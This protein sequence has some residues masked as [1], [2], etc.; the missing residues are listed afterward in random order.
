VRIGRAFALLIGAGLVL[1][2]LAVLVLSLPA[3]AVVGFDDTLDS[4]TQP[5]A[6]DTAAIASAEASL[7]G[8]AARPQAQR[9]GQVE[10]PA[11]GRHRA[12]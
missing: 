7:G 10:P 4:G 9:R 6:S 3:L 1:V 5:L 12:T 8:H 11:A 2:G